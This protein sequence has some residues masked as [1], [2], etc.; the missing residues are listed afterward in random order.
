MPAGFGDLTL[1]NTGTSLDGSTVSE[2][3]AIANQ[4]LAGNGL[5][6]GYSFSDLNELITNLN[7]SW[8]NCVESEWAQQHLE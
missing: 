4:A 2:I 8:D 3:L 7:E 6:V 5:P 1:V